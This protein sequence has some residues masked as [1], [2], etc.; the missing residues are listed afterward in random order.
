MDESISFSRFAR[1]NGGLLQR[2]FVRFAANTLMT[3]LA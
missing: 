3:L 2:E 1:T